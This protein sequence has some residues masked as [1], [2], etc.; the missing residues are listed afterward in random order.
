M[1]SFSSRSCFNQ[2]HLF[3]RS[4]SSWG[5]KEDEDDLGNQRG[6][7]AKP[8]FPKDALCR[9]ALLFITTLVSLAP[10]GDSWKVSFSVTINASTV[11]L[12]KALVKHTHVRSSMLFVSWVPGL[13]H[14]RA[15]TCGEY[16]D[17]GIQRTPRFSALTV[18]VKH[19]LKQSYKD[20]FIPQS[21]FCLI[22]PAG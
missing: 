14:A 22:D 15:Q 12:R 16:E 11:I 20:I 7:D 4:H 6:D 5:K 17:I 9:G 19:L 18:I 21:P 2:P 10:W 1:E 13:L 3:F 8:C